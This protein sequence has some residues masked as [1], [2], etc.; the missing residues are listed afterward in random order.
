MADCLLPRPKDVFATAT[1][2]VKLECSTHA[3]VDQ[4]F[5]Y[6]LAA[7]SV[8]EGKTDDQLKMACPTD[9]AAKYFVAMALKRHPWTP[10]KMLQLAIN[11]KCPKSITHSHYSSLLARILLKKLSTSCQKWLCNSYNNSNPNAWHIFV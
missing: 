8:R 10:T 3:C 4:I 9:A 1:K 7:L 5:L 6:P 2:V 11:S